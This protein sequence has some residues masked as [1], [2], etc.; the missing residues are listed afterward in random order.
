MFPGQVYYRYE[1]VETLLV[2]VFNTGQSTLGE[3]EWFDSIPSDWRFR[4]VKQIYSIQLGKML[5]PEPSTPDEMEVVYLKSQHVQWGRVRTEDLPSMWASESDLAKYEIV[6]G[7]LLV[8]EGGDVGRAGIAVN[9][10]SKI[11]IQNALHRVRP[12]ANSCVRYFLY[13]LSHAASQK[14]FEI[15]CNRS[16]IA[17]LTSEKLGALKIPCPQLAEQQAIARFLDAKTTQIDALV[18]KKRQL[19]EKLNEKRQA[20]IS[21]CVTQGLPPE[22]AR[23]AG[24]NPNPEMKES[25]VGWFEQ[26]PV[27]WNLKPIKELAIPGGKSFTDGDWV[28]LPYITDEGV[29]LLQTGNVGIGRFKE[30]GFRY[31]SDESFETLEC[32]EVVPN[33]VLICRLDGPVGRGCLAPNLGVRMITSVDNTIL[34]VREDICPKYVVYF[35]SSCYWLNWIDALCRVGGGFRIRISRTMLGNIRIPMPPHD[36]QELIVRYL[37]QETGN[38]DSLIATAESTIEI[39]LEYRKAL[40]TAAVTGKINVMESTK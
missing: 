30:Q 16:T 29:R 6:D 15:I 1:S 18:G 9:L 8:C 20:L 10:P 3:V 38:L 28:E 11:I 14:W 26:F 36:D 13:I 40:I 25:G 39:L 22:A 35:L 33:D 4:S 12:G 19:I 7:D 21:R 34:K 17:H 24:Q 37:D 5:Q 23:A 27:H 2:N 31:V 32:T